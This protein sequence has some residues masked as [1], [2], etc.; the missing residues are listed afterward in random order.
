MPEVATLAGVGRATASPTN[1]I[2]VAV[3]HEREQR[4]SLTSALSELVQSVDSEG[5]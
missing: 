1:P 5:Q 3:G 4:L 2:E